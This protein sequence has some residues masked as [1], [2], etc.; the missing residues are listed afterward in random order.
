VVVCDPD[1]HRAERLRAAFPDPERVRLFDRLDDLA[2]ECALRP[3]A[4]VLL[5]FPWGGDVTAPANVDPV[6]R[7]LRDFGKVTAALV[8]A[9]T[10]ALPINL[11]CRP[12]ACGARQLVNEAGP[13]FLQDL[14]SATDRL[15]E[16]YRSRGEEEEQLGAL[17]GGLGLQACSAPMREVFRRIIKAAH[18]SDLP[19]L[20]LGETG[21]GKQRIAEAIHALD[22]RRRDKP[23]ITINCSAL[24]KSLAESELFGHARG[25]FSGAQGE[26]KGLFRAAN[27][28]TLLL[29]EIGDLDLELQPKLLRVLQDRRLLPVG[30]DYE[31]PVDVRIIAATHCPL[32]RMIEEGRFRGDLYQ[33]LNI[34]RI[35][36]PSLR[37]R[38]EDISVQAYTFLRQYQANHPSSVTG[39]GPRVLELLR[40]LPWEGNTR[41]LENCIREAL[42][43]KESVGPLLE[44]TDLPRWALEKV[45]SLPTEPAERDESAPSIDDLVER[46]C[47]ERLSFAQAIEEYERRLLVR[48][49]ELTGGNRTHAAARLGLTPRTIFAKIRKYQLE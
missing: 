35:Q 5:P 29:D 23:F 45:T 38:P 26:R 42:A 3:P 31:H 22:P 16:D 44:L 48:V 20:V 19:V 30:E 17:F 39:F 6:L 7:F 4:V 32:E 27:G 46:A 40:S 49:L 36:V 13:G 33:R 11:Y 14:V 47:A 9:D 10:H 28:G 37:E 34:F 15:A 24:S 25:A 18:F 41:Q 2:R 1:P 12:L 8:Y 21:T 43:Q